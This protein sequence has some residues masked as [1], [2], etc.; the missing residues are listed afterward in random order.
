MVRERQLLSGSALL[1][2]TTSDRRREQQRSGE[3]GT[4]KRIGDVV[5]SPCHRREINRALGGEPRRLAVGSRPLLSGVER[6]T[7]DCTFLGGKS[8]D[9]LARAPVGGVIEM[10]FKVTKIP[11]KSVSDESTGYRGCKKTSKGFGWGNG[12]G[13]INTSVGKLLGDEWLIGL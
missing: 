10:W 7:L 13:A 5:F 11:S 1:P 8:G 4:S 3:I 6:P 12:T 9:G 2:R